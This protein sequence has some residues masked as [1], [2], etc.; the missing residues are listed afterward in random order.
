M[1]GLGLIYL[2]FLRNQRKTRTTEDFET[3]F[4]KMKFVMGPSRI[5]EGA[6]EVL[7]SPKMPIFYL[8]FDLDADNDRSARPRSL[9]FSLISKKGRYI[10]PNTCIFVSEIT[11]FWANFQ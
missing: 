2:Q 1:H 3:F 4:M 11:K 8:L 6:I 7:F 9:G 5:L 10:K